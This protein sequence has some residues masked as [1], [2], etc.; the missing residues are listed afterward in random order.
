MNEKTFKKLFPEVELSVC[1]HSIQNFGNS[2]ADVYILGQFRTY[3]QFRGRKYL[4][5]FIV[6]N[7]NDCPNILSHGAI[8]RMGILVP[9]YP[10]ENMVKLGDMET[11]TSNV[12][13][14]LQDLR[15][16]QYQGNSEPKA[17]GPSTTF[18]TS[19][20]KPKT[21]KSHKTAS[22][23]AGM[24]IYIDNT[25]QIQTSFR[26]MP[27]PKTSACGTIPTPELKA[28]TSHSTRR[29]ASRTHQLYS[30]IEPPACCMHVHQQQSQTCK[31]G[32]PP[33]LREVKHPHRDRTSVSRSP[34]TEQ[35]VLSQFSGYS[36]EIEHFTRDPCKS[37]LKSCF[38]S[39]KHAPKKQEVNTCTN[40]EHSYRMEHAEHFSAPMEM[41]MD[42]HLT[43]TTERIQQQ[44]L[45]DKTYEQ[46][47]LTHH[48]SP[49]FNFSHAEFP[50]G[51][52]N[53]QSFLGKQFLQGKETITRPD[54]ENTPALLWN[55]S[56]QGNEKNMDTCTFTSGSTT[57]NRHSMLSTLTHPRRVPQNFQQ[58]EMESSNTVALP[59]FN[60][61]AEASTHLETPKNVHDKGPVSTN[62][63]MYTNMNANM[64]TN[65]MAHRYRHTEKEVHLLSEPSELQPLKAMAH[66]YTEKE[67]HLLSEPSELQPLK[68]MA[69]RYIRKEDHLLSGPSVLQPPEETQKFNST[70]VQQ[71][72]QEYSRSTETEKAKFQDPFIYNDDRNFV[73]HNSVDKFSPNLVYMTTPN[74]S[75]VS[76]SVF[77]RKK[78][79]KCRDSRNYRGRSTC[80]CTCSCTHTGE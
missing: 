28:N 55:Q 18:M 63:K 47:C 70:H 75:S 59:C 54:M 61:N 32:K 74:T 11:A 10:E 64:D 27:P 29:P 60:H 66:R 71:P 65:H 42:D 19:T 48:I 2:T 4:N 41:C 46:N 38:Q 8:F 45:Q 3:L 23:K 57:P 5:T 67:A 14:V 35:E 33:A 26:T 56:I 34:S 80:T 36:E 78:G 6:T 20:I 25:S 53:T 7:A 58:L 50:P 73:R 79:R 12:F 52:E 51:M 24:A 49:D 68:A 15:M 69:H 31:T 1:P 44:H 13:Q 76:N 37:H 39:T 77:F 30:H 16:K 40:C 17:H 43:Q 62:L 21:P 22:Q 9:D 72:R